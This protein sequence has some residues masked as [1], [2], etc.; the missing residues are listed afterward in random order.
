MI[1]H[2]IV[3]SLCNSCTY[4]LHTIQEN[5]CCLV[6]CGDM[7]PIFDYL[8]QQN[9]FVSHLLLTHTH[10][11]HI[12]GMKKLMDSFPDCIIYTSEW[13]VKGLASDKLNLSRYHNESIIW[14]GGNIKVLHEG[15]NVELFANE[16]LE[17]LETPGHDKSCLTYKIGSNLFTGDSFIPGLKVA[18]S[19]PNSNKEDAE[20]SLQR[21]W[22]LSSNCHLYPGHISL[23]NSK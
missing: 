11:D 19:F 7:T 8:M 15:D 23:Y 5:Q 20:L 2:S 12:Y 21:I 4:V 14:T 3:N 22:S 17:V 16:V 1:I 9:L 13:G 10:Y 18:F 6:D